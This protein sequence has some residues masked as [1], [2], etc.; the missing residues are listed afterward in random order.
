MKVEN[1]C[2]STDA[3]WPFSPHKPH[4]TQIL[5]GKKNSKMSNKNGET[6]KKSETDVL[7]STER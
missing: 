6:E 7:D 1:I 5:R 4:E 2:P 3:A